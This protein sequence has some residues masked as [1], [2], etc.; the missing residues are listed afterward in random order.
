MH[1]V[2]MIP[3]SVV[4]VS[5]SASTVP[6]MNFSSSST[7]TSDFASPSFCG[8]ST[9]MKSGRVFCTFRPRTADPNPRHAIITPVFG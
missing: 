1:V 2:A 6:V 9:T 8:S 3:D 7:L 5:D 4:L